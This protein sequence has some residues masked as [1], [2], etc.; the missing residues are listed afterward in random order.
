MVDPTKCQALLEVLCSFFI[1][2]TDN[3]SSLADIDNKKEKKK[4]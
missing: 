4:L 3:V 1:S 2:E